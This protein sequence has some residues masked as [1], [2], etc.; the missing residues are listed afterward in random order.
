MSNSSLEI[1]SI[2]RYAKLAALLIGVF[3]LLSCEAGPSSASNKDD[4][5][6]TVM[7]PTATPIE[8]MNH[9]ATE[10]KNLRDQENCREFFAAFP[11]T[12]RD[13]DNL[14]GFDDLEGEHPLFANASDHIEYFFGCSDIP[15][16]ERIEKAVGISLHG[17]WA[18]DSV[19]MFR[20]HMHQIVV[21]FPVEVQSFL[22]SLSDADASSFWYFM[23]DGPHPEHPEVEKRYKT[24]LE[25]VGSQSKQTKLVKKQY[26]KLLN[27]KAH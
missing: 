16:N 5:S 10:M 4:S 15:Q 27:S 8:T 14:Y 11:A 20:E 24:C 3:F 12:F 9:K 6:L 18:A 13:F 23:L 17:K 25:I 22:E 26:E 7:T 1:E 19:W 21:A 2:S